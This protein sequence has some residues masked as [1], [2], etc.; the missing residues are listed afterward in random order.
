MLSSVCVP[1]L[2]IIFFDREC[3]GRWTEWWSACSASERQRFLV[4]GGFI[5]GLNGKYVHFDAMRPVDACLP[6]P[7]LSGTESAILNRESSDSESCDSQVTLSI[8]SQGP[9][10]GAV[11]NGGASRSG[12]VL[13]FWSFSVLFGTFPIFLGF[14]RF[15]RGWS[16]DFPD[17]S[18]SSFSAY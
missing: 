17:L 16:G 8:D 11:S 2:C 1:L 14:S 12:L 5:G 3:L 6:R 7:G 4:R 13:P 10:N 15:A 9:L 18:F